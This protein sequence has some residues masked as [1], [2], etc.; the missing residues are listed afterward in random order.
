MTRPNSQRAFWRSL[1]R[2]GPLNTQPR[3]D[4]TIR[5]LASLYPNSV[6]ASLISHADWIT[7]LRISKAAKRLTRLQGKAF[8]VAVEDILASSYEVG[9]ND[10]E[11]RAVAA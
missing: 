11:T 7:R 3:P 5:E 4:F 9:T 8:R 10:K 2:R 1:G 6:Y